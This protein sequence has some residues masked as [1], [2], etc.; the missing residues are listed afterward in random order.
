ME[1]ADEAASALAKRLDDDPWPLVRSAAASALGRLKGRATVTG[2]LTD[3]L[4]DDS[5]AVRR[6]VL[7]ALGTLGA[8][9][10][11]PAVRERLEDSEELP[12]V[13]AAAALALGMMCDRTSVDALTDYARKLADPQSP[14]KDVA[15]SA[16]TALSW[17][18]PP[19]LAER[20]QPLRARDAG[21]G[22][23]RAADTALTGPARCRAGGK[24]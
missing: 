6:P 7:L 8:L 18:H 21:P 12:P 15:Q 19:D 24:S 17:I 13:R 14:L 22:V 1:R 9:D 5:A 4:D 20:V 10:A 23:R 16:L 2:A 11:A 3:A